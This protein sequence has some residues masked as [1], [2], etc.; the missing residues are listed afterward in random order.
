MDNGTNQEGA[1]S[2][3]ETAPPQL[4]DGSMTK[5]HSVLRI[6]DEQVLPAKLDTHPSDSKEF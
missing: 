6:L 1:R 3:K 5:A 4:L 2:P